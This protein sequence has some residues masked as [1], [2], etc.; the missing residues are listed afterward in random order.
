[1]RGQGQNSFEGGINADVHPLV[2]KPNQL[3][4]AVNME[5]TTAGE[6]QYVFQNM[7]GNTEAF[8]LSTMQHE[9]Q[10]LAFRP[11]AVKTHNEIGYIISGAFTSEGKFVAGEVG[12]YPSPNWNLQ[13][14]GDSSSS[15]DYP[16]VTGPTMPYYYGLL[17]TVVFDA[18]SLS[19]ELNTTLHVKIPEEIATRNTHHG[20]KVTIRYA[21]YG[22][23]SKTNCGFMQEEYYTKPA[24]YENVFSHKDITDGAEAFLHISDLEMRAVVVIIEL[25]WEWDVRPKREWYSPCLFYGATKPAYSTGGYYDGTETNLYLLAKSVI[26]KVAKTP[27]GDDLTTFMYEFYDKIKYP[28][29]VFDT[30]S[31][32]HIDPYSLNG[33]IEEWLLENVE[34]FKTTGEFFD[35]S[36]VEV[37]I[38]GVYSEEIFHSDGNIESPLQNKY[39]P[40]HNFLTD[41]FGDTPTD[42]DFLNDLA[43]VNIF[44]TAEFN[45]SLDSFIDLTLQIDYDNTIN[46]I[47][48]DDVNPIKLINTRFRKNEDGSA[49]LIDRAGYKDSNTYSNRFFDG[50]NLIL[51]VKTIPKLTFLGLDDTGALLGGGYRYYFRYRTIEGDVSDI[52]EE[53]RLVTI[54]RGEGDSTVGVPGD[55]VTSRKVSFKLSGLDSTYSSIQVSYTHSFGDNTTTANVQ[56]I[57]ET[58]FIDRFGE[59]RIDHSGFE[60]L[61]DITPE[62]LSEVS[63]SIKTAKTVEQINGRL[64]IGNVSGGNNEALILD[65]VE[66]TSLIEIKELH[67]TSKFDY[68]DPMT[69]YTDL[70]YWPG[71]TY[72]LGIVYITKHGQTPAI[73]LR[74]IDNFDGKANYTNKKFDPENQIA[75]EAFEN[76]LGIYR[77]QNIDT[78]EGEEFKI[79]K[80]KIDLRPLKTAKLSSDILGFYIVRKNRI[81]DVLYSGVIAPTTGI[82]SSN[83][84]KSTAEFVGFERNT[85]FIYTDR[86]LGANTGDD[87][88]KIG[89]AG[90]T[91]LSVTFDMVKI[92]VPSA[93]FLLMNTGGGI[94]V[95][96]STFGKNKSGAIYTPDLDLIAPTVVGNIDNILRGVEIGE[97]QCKTKVPPV[98]SEGIH[99]VTGG[100]FGITKIKIGDFRYVADGSLAYGNGNFSSKIESTLSYILFNG[101]DPVVYS[102]DNPIT[103]TGSFT[104]SG[105]GNTPLFTGWGVNNTTAW[106]YKSAA[107][108]LYPYASLTSNFGSYIGVT[109]DE[110]DVVKPA[111]SSASS[112]SI[113]GWATQPVNILNTSRRRTLED[114]Y[115]IYSNA[116]KSSMYAISERVSMDSIPDYLEVGDGDCFVGPMYKKI[117]Y[118]IGIEEAPTAGIGNAADYGTGPEKKYDEPEAGWGQ[119]AAHERRDR[120]RNLHPQGYVLK[121]YTRSEHNFM[122]RSEEFVDPLETELFGKRTFKPRSKGSAYTYYHAPDS[123]AYNTGYSG[124]Y[125][126][127]VVSA[128]NIKAPV[129]T[130]T[131]QN[132]V[133]VSAPNI[134]STFVNGYR[135]IRGINFKDYNS[136]L[137]MITKLINFNNSLYC[138]FEEGMGIITVDGRTLINKENEIFVDD[139]QALASKAA[140]LSSKIGSINMESIVLSDT[141][142]YGVDLVKNKIWKV[143]GKG[144]KLISDFATQTIINKWL[145]KLNNNTDSEGKSLVGKFRLYSVFSSIKKTIHFSFGKLLNT[146]EDFRFNSFAGSM[147]Y[148]EISSSWVSTTSVYTRFLFGFL[149]RE[150]STDTILAT[151]SIWLID[152]N[153]A[154]CNFYGEQHVNSFEYVMHDK[155]DVEK[156][157]TNLIFM[158]N[159]VKPDNIT[160]RITADLTDGTLQ[161][162][163][164]I[165]LNYSIHT[166]IIHTRSE[167]STSTIGLFNENAYYKDGKYFVQVGKS[168]S[169]SRFDKHARMIRDKFFKIKVEYTGEQHV[170][171]YALHTQYIVNYD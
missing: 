88:K 76:A 114:L 152:S 157:L 110:E 80:L 81:K 154:Y 54:A 55:E 3:I 109:F 168:R 165:D 104:D 27:V 119:S 68:K 15:D 140:I 37:A 73:P 51:A 135:D 13:V 4:D 20:V 38:D 83:H 57:D 117:V 59:C 60:N 64:V 29:S 92:P 161:Q 153:S 146:K 121:Y 103:A 101:L 12:T 159:K 132:R 170:Y 151:N 118:P 24:L 95:Y 127:V 112:G 97:T 169:F 19:K 138:I 136:E 82:P 5:L 77:T 155:P 164:D 137:G 21:E 120:G 41:E 47:F 53:S 8:S 9:G 18:T 89:S 52:I 28:G 87:L 48:T 90:E 25:N 105:S 33:Y 162:I 70:G 113:T 10:T 147:Y 94:Y 106:R 78:P 116:D 56:T 2:V 108:F 129:I 39:A 72:E 166:D 115:D 167:F 69:V 123:S 11:L 62:T 34:P 98:K 43:H 102:R 145:N 75:T 71:E 134:V 144:I 131:Y 85:T 26:G 163:Q 14:S 17:T 126:D 36:T 58:F 130:R 99:K 111:T 125:R 66:V 74:G 96:G 148:S 139:A 31:V 63:T 84:R 30:G 142:V 133:I 35:L 22:L 42:Y 7:R 40:L 128:L 93:A 16:T 143:N 149:S 44:R 160:Y 107:N 86:L 141:A 150:Y 23:L 46:F 156:M 45:F 100:K 171:I 61:I 91:R 49:T 50:T 6:D 158:S 67:K 79:I 65:L 124:N 1:M 122:I 32:S